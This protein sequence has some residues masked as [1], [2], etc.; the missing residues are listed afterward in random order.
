MEYRITLTHDIIMYIILELELYLRRCHTPCGRQYFDCGG[1]MLCVMSWWG[2]L[3]VVA[4]SKPQYSSHLR[5][6]N[7]TWTRNSR[8]TRIIPESVPWLIANNRLEEAKQILH[9]AARWNKVELPQK[10]RPATTAAPL[11][12]VSAAENEQNCPL[13]T[14]EEGP[15]SVETTTQYTMVDLF[16]SRRLT[17]NLL[18]MFYLW[19]VIARMNVW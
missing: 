19:Y 18:V 12:R 15:V 7:W 13:M 4:S 16:R 8:S 3:I 6:S 10:Y 5:S 9:K 1:W 2:A 11:T 17:V 14:K